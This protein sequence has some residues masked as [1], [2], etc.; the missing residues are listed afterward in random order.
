MLKGNL[1][2]PQSPNVSLHTFL[3]LNLLGISHF[4]HKGQRVLIFLFFF[5]LLFAVFACAKGA[6]VVFI[7]AVVAAGDPDRGCRGTCMP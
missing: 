6:F 3:C 1:G 2:L 7:S 5:F 4:P